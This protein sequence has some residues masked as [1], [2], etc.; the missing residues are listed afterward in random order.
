[1]KWIKPALSHDKGRADLGGDP[2]VPS[3]RDRRRATAKGH[4]QLI[5]GDLV[6]QL[7]RMNISSQRTSV[8][9][10]SLVSDNYWHE[11]QVHVDYPKSDRMS[12]L[13]DAHRQS[14][15]LLQKWTDQGEDS[16]S[17][18]ILDD[19]DPTKTSTPAV[20][21]SVGNKSNDSKSS[22]L[23]SSPSQTSSE[24]RTRFPEKLWLGSAREP[25]YTS[26]GSK[27]HHSPSI[28]NLSKPTENLVAPTVEIFKSFRVNMDDPCYKVL[29]AALKKYH[30]QADWRKYR[31]WLAFEGQER[32]IGLEERPVV[33][34]KQLAEE[35]KRPMY[36]IRRAPDYEDI[37]S[38]G[39]SSDHS[40]FI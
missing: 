16:P 10:N 7:E 36:M 33:L 8:I 11:S 6:L 34:F 23:P 27:S 25:S 24:S 15:Y 9:L 31:L 21:S 2:N 28:V 38:S 20:D 37:S 18:T 39:G 3:L 1:M 19:S 12:L 26:N 35:G 29:P 5:D 32:L 22:P 17:P 40:G 4:P 14:T 13:V 30:I